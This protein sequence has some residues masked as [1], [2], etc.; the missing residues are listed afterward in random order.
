[1]QYG[2]DSEG[3]GNYWCVRS[4][5]VWGQTG[6][7]YVSPEVRVNVGD[8]MDS[9][10]SYNKASSIWTIY[11]NNKNSQKPTTLTVTKA[12]AGNTDYKVAMLVLETIMPA[13]QCNL[14]PSPPANVL[15]TGIKVNG[16]D[17]PWI[18]RVA[19]KDCKQRISQ[20][21]SA[22]TVNFLWN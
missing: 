1:L 16:A 13:N 7:A 14:L 6:T 4:W 5:F 11:A 20:D 21:K 19:M 15:F 10:M 8:I 9:Y 18:E 22:K 3:G 17:A 2:R 12:K